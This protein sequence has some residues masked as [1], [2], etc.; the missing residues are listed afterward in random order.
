MESI[1]R[2][3]NVGQVQFR[4]FYFSWGFYFSAS[5]LSYKKIFKYF[6]NEKIINFKTDKILI[7]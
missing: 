1:I 3:V 2:K 5:T 6:S 7:G 4:N